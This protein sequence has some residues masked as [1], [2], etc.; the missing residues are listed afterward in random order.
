M[1]TGIITHIGIIDNLSYQKNKDLL[2]TIKLKDEKLQRKMV[3]GCS[4]ACC[5]ICLT[6]VKKTKRGNYFYLDFIASKET[7]NKTNI[8]DWKIGRKI[9]LEFALRVGD[10][11]GGHLVLGHI[12]DVAII[13]EIKKIKTS[14]CFTLEAPPPLKKFICAKGSITLNGISL[15]INELKDN[16]FS[17]NI[18]SHT[19]ENTNLQSAKIGD[20]VNLEIDLIARYLK[21][22]LDY[23]E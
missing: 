3:L 22:L 19:F 6:L 18:I 12:D 15:T 10:E 13:K 5:G 4:I 23:Q 2:I 9:N 7:I 21:N 8:S 17:V 16:S 14:Y 11:L 20:R 1:F